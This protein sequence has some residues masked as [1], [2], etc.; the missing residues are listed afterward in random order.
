M[1]FGL[2]L[3]V[4]IV[5]TTVVNV[6]E[7]GRGVRGG[8]VAQLARQPRSYWGMIVAH[9]GIAVFIVGVTMVKGY[10]TERDVRMDVGDTVDGRRLH[11]A[12]RRHRRESPGPNYRAA[13]GAFEVSRDGST[14]T[15]LLPEKRVYN[16]GGMPMTEAAIDVGAA[17]RPVRVAR[18]A[19]RRRRAG[20]CASI[21]S[22]SSPGSGAAAC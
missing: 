13:R 2:L 14:S 8:V 19:G 18:R 12:L 1:S 3:A 22:R 17:R 6:R 21:T 20:A 9:L 10:E 5:A 15:T 4:W 16:A 7:R 11:A